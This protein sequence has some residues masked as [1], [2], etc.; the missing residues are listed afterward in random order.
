MAKKG[1]RKNK[2]KQSQITSN[3]GT[4]AGD[5]TSVNQN[6]TINDPAEVT[7]DVTKPDDLNTEE[8]AD[9]DT[10][11]ERA[12]EDNLNTSITGDASAVPA[13][14]GDVP[15]EISSNIANEEQELD[16]NTLPN[17]KVD[18]EVN[19]DL[20][21]K[22]GGQIEAEVPTNKLETEINETVES[23]SQLK[24]SEKG[25]KVPRS[26]HADP[27]IATDTHD[28]DLNKDAQDGIVSGT[29]V[30]QDVE[31]GK[32]VDQLNESQSDLHIDDFD[33]TSED[34]I[35]EDNLNKTGID[36]SGNAFSE[37]PLELEVTKKNV[38]DIGK[39]KES[40]AEEEVVPSQKNIENYSLTSPK[41]DKDTS[42]GS[43][44]IAAESTQDELEE[45]DF[46]SQ[47]VT[48]EEPITKADEAEIADKESHN[49]TNY[50]PEEESVNNVEDDA[51]IKSNEDNESKSVSGVVDHDRE[52]TPENSARPTQTLN[53]VD[54]APPPLPVRNDEGSKNLEPAIVSPPPLP[55]RSTS[56]PKQPSN[57]FKRDGEPSDNG[58]PNAW[59][60]AASLLETKTPISNRSFGNFENYATPA[61]SRFIS[62]S[63][64]QM[65]PVD[66]TIADVNLIVN[67]FR[68]A[69]EQIGDVN[70]S[71]REGIEAGHSLLISSYTQLLSHHDEGSNEEPVAVEDLELKELST[72]DWTFWTGVVNNF[73]TV[74][75]QS[76]DKLEEEIT[77]GI[78]RR[79]RGIIWQLIASSKSQEIE[80]LYQ[81]LF[82]TESSH[83]SNIKRD[84]QR[85]NFIPQDKVDSLFNILRVY[86]IFDPD[87]GYTQGMAFIA[88]PLLLNCNSEAEAFGLLIAL[89]KNYNVRSFFLPE[90]PGLMLM[91]YQFD[92]L[93]EE[94]VPTLSNH[95]QREG[96]RSSMYATQ[97]F[98]TVFAYKFPL[99]FVLRIFDIIFFEGIESLLKFA[100]NLMIK[101][102]ESLVTLRFDKLLTF[103]KNELFEY[104]LR[105]PSDAES[106]VQTDLEASVKGMSSA[107]VVLDHGHAYEYHVDL[108]VR[109]AMNDVHITPIS[110]NRYASE[111]E[112]LHQLERV[113]QDEFES[114][115]VKNFQLE[116]EASKLS[117]E[118][119]LLD[120]E[121]I[122]IAKEL[123]QYRLDTETLLDENRDLTK[124]VETLE[125]QLSD[126]KAKQSVPNPDAALPVD[127]RGDLERTMKRNTEVVAL[128]SQLQDRI[129]DLEHTV[130]RL[131]FENKKYAGRQNAVDPPVGDATQTASTTD[132]GDPR[133]RTST[134]S[135]LSSGWSGFKKVFKK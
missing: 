36:E 47:P 23:I 48:E 92:R 130:R 71:V 17:L 86:S 9:H 113:K 127:L 58:I 61:R 28:N 22:E 55:M 82:S 78:P 120:E 30:K 90:M 119:A 76:P 104:Y 38:E 118:Y 135:T 33:I 41:K 8:V 42:L 21:A 132:G 77:R 1:K 108:F 49:E 43:V 18:R 25:N 16:L 39:S 66:P 65:S 67:R 35:D 125:T 45:I 123:I 68:V 115:R 128:N 24:E 44:G 14:A 110:L 95:L 106:V 46:N 101:N 99:E 131:I 114:L 111:Y 40:D 64:N 100:V 72:T 133:E 32:N 122:S 2:S 31:I 51:N 7:A 54:A 88:T 75:N 117:H 94:N 80:D 37:E 20:S 3:T 70:P 126:L 50:R 12:D 19:E 89:M 57:G 74:A 87:V 134:T 26:P 81:T 56:T 121:H 102:E 10:T 6:E 11:A 93:L 124:N 97:W 53:E 13:S 69:S 109:D 4:I 84:L 103:L 52:E 15:E 34:L 62:T 60:P 107:E 98:L 29:T 116:K 96:V 83:E 112:D 79:I 129:D 5:N 85:T 59:T 63:S 91:M 73:A 27:D 105:E